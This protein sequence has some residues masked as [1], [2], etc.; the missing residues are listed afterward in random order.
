MLHDQNHIYT[1]P[2]EIYPDIFP[3]INL[4]SCETWKTLFIRTNPLFLIIILFLYYTPLYILILYSLIPY[5]I[6]TPACC[7][8][9]IIRIYPDIDIQ[10][11]H[12]NKFDNLFAFIRIKTGYW[13]RNNIENVLTYSPFYINLSLKW[14]SR[15]INQYQYKLGDVS[16]YAISDIVQH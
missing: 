4:S 9:F 14:I 6:P 11:A 1:R 16:Q 12:V 10:W 2:T 13:Y 3:Y 7:Y 5:Y 8:W 15:Y